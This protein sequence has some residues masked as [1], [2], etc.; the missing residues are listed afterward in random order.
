MPDEYMRK[1]VEGV[2]N[3]YGKE[4]F[5]RVCNEASKR[6]GVLFVIGKQALKHSTVGST[7]GA[8]EKEGDLFLVTNRGLHINNIVSIIPLS[9]VDREDVMKLLR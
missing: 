6:R 9:A 2:F 7:F 4:A 1:F 5:V 3:L 8:T